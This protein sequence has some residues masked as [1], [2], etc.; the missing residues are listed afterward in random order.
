M[1]QHTGDTGAHGVPAQS[2]R[3]RHFTKAKRKRFL[4]TLAETCNVSRSAR[5][6]G[7]AVSSC[8]RLRGRDS[9]FDADWGTAM[10]VGFKRLEEALLQYAL[11]AVTIEDSADADPDT[12][13]AERVGAALRE[14]VISHS[15]LQ[16][17]A[18]LLA[19]HRPAEG[20]RATPRG[21]GEATAAEVDA[22][23]RRKLDQLARR[24]DKA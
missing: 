14:R 19:R 9:T 22:V 8:Y 5:A 2:G 16:F 18:A 15:D 10:E 11:G 7:V 24:I 23:L 13:T 20:K 6:A 3:T 1:A 4:D 12:I 21:P 17:A